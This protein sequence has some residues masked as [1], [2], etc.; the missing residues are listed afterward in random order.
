[1]RNENYLIL[2]NGVFRERKQRIRL[3]DKRGEMTKN[4]KRINLF[5]IQVFRERLSEKLCM[6]QSRK[7]ICDMINTLFLTL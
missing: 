5:E 3:I 4:F 2:T 1:M 7:V 6:R